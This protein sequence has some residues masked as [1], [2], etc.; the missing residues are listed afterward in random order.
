MVVDKKR[1]I[2]ERREACIAEELCV[3]AETD[4]DADKVCCMRPLVGHDGCDL[5]ILALEALDGLAEGKM[6]TVGGEVL[7]HALGEWCI[8]VRG[9]AGRRLVDERDL[10]A[11]AL[12]GFGE[13]DTDIA[14]TDD[15]DAPDCLIPEL[16]DYGL[17]ILEELHLLD[18]LEVAS[19]PAGK[20]RHRASCQDQPVVVLLI[21]LAVGPFC[22]EHLGIVVDM[23]HTGFHV[24]SCTL[25]LELLLRLVEEAIGLRDLPSD[26]QCHAAAEE[27]DV[28]V[29]VEDDDVVSGMVVEYRIGCC[30]ACMVGADNHDCAH[31]E[32]LS[33]CFW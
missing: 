4:A 10:L 26:P 5:A 27:A 7:C 23:V 22:I 29:L 11:A 2:A 31:G 28:R 18:I 19:F 24:D 3:R 14:G 17:G 8:E 9:G 6:D 33:F 20:H 32:V 16:F 30:R 1:S 15:G 13:L 25:C 21:R 12:E